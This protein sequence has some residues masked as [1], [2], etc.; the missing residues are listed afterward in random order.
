[1]GRRHHAQADTVR[2]TK[3]DRRLVH[4]KERQGVRAALAREEPDAVVDPVLPHVATHARPE[5]PPRRP[6][7]RHWKLPFWK[8]RTAVRRERALRSLT[9]GTA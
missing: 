6:R 8:R 1:M 3:Y 4:H 7:A 5:I 2:L 9:S